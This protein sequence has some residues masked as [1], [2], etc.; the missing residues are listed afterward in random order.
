MS[1][2]D[3]DMDE[4]YIALKNSKFKQQRLA[5][6]RPI[7]TITNTTVI[8]V[9]FGIAF[10]IIG[11]IVLIYSSKIVEI[12][13]Q[14]DDTCTSQQKCTVTINIK[15]KMKAPVMLYYQIDNFYQNHRRYVKSKSDKQLNGKYQSLKEIE[16]SGDCDPVITNEDIGRNESYNGSPLDPKAVAIPCGL[17]AKSL[18]NDT[19]ELYKGATADPTQMV[20]ID[21]KDIAWAADKEL[22]YKNIKPQGGKTWEELQWTNM[23]DEH[24][25]VWMRLAGLPNFRKLYGRIREDLQGVYTFQIQNHFEVASFSGKK[26]IVISTVNAF[27]GKNNFLGISYIVVGA[28]FLIF[29]IVF[30]V[31]YK[32]HN[33]KKE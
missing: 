2:E 28:M 21:D 18:F 1:K 19:Y 33:R 6:W 13:R 20:P 27:G 11:V 5:A 22:K 32:I 30:L 26:Y 7:P 8:F 25:I 15:D 29:A 24:F 16:D 9:V 4:E 14:Y 12:Q 31:G 17:I 3:A 23:E 10:I